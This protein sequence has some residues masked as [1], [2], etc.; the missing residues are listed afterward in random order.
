MTVPPVA[1]ALGRLVSP[2]TF[3]VAAAVQPFELAVTVT[4]YAPAALAVGFCEVDVNPF[5]P[6]QLY[7]APDAGV[8]VRLTVGVGQVIGPF[9]VA[10]AAGGVLFRFT[11]AVAVAVQLFELLVTVTV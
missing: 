3:T 11:V 10:P 2:V 6:L 9:T 5:G 8:A 1:V 7:V 4:I